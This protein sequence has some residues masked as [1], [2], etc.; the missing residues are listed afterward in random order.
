MEILVRLGTLTLTPFDGCLF[1][2]SGT[3]ARRGGNGNQGSSSYNY[4]RKVWFRRI[5]ANEMENQII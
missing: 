1:R 3:I 4:R 2:V 5:C